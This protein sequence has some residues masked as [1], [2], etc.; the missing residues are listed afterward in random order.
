MQQLVGGRSLRTQPTSVSAL[1][2]HTAFHAYAPE[3][4]DAGGV[5]GAGLMMWGMPVWGVKRVPFVDSTLCFCVW[6]G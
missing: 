5:V 1:A 2:V 4:F 6:Q 3:R